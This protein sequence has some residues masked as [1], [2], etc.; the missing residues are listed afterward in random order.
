MRPADVANAHRISESFAALGSRTKQNARGRKKRVK[1]RVSLSVV[2]DYP[3]S[4]LHI[5]SSTATVATSTLF[6]RKRFHEP[7]AVL[8]S[9]VA[10][11][12][13]RL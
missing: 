10:N 11:A 8:P 4:E 6:D 1:Q 13:G 12:S 5:V 7:A 9:D 2:G 3:A